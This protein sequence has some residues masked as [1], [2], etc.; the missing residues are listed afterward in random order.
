MGQ[1]FSNL[2]L[3]F[4]SIG[5]IYW[6]LKDRISI[7]EAGNKKILL[8]ALHLT[9]CVFK[10]FSFKNVSR[11]DSSPVIHPANSYNCLGEG[12][13]PVSPGFQTTHDYVSWAPIILNNMLVPS[14]K[15][16]FY[17]HFDGFMYMPR[18]LIS[19]LTVIHFA[20]SLLV[21]LLYNLILKILFEF[22]KVCFSFSVRTQRHFFPFFPLQLELIKWLAMLIC[23]TITKSR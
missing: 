8:Y 17:K 10:H 3:M 4:S 9:I 13:S 16:Y 7:G 23:Q 19:L 5:Y 12:K 14:M 21:C 20:V 18:L 6:S 15:N 1:L 22:A 11:N 2:L